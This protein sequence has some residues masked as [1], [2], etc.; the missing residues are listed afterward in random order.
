MEL[1]WLNKNNSDTIIIFFSG[2]GQSHHYFKENLTSKVD[3]LMVNNYCHLDFSTLEKNIID[4]KRKEVIGWSFG[5][6]IAGLFIE[7]FQNID[8]STSINGSL[9]PIDDQDG[10]PKKIFEGT[11]KLL[12]STSWEKFA[13]R[14]IG[15]RKIYNEFLSSNSRSI[16]SLKQE[17]AFLGDCPKVKN[18][19]PFDEVLISTK[20]RIFP[21][22]NLRHYWERNNNSFELLETH[23]FPFH[24]YNTW[25]GITPLNQTLDV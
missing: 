23:H 6:Q 9:N 24:H 10:I 19:I 2:W 13:F 12:S 16:A 20:D 25:E 7:Q 5:V 15:D 4:Y 11:L 1:H 22:E 21:S 3:V 18:H 14:M 17:L 8:Y